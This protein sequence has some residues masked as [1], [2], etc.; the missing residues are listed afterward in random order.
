MHPLVN[1]A[2][3]AARDASKM[4]LQ[5]FDRL[6][7]ITVNE[8]SRNDFV[9]DVD[10]AAE[11]MIIEHIL[12]RYPDHHITAEES[13]EHGAEHHFNWIIDPLDGTANFI[14]GIPHFAISI[15]VQEKGRTI[16]AM[17]YDP[18][19]DELF[20]AA[21]GEGARLNDRKL[22]VS[23][24]KTLEGG[25]IGTGFPFRDHDMLSDYLRGFET[26]FRQCA[27]IRRNGAAAL[28]LAYVAAGRYAGF[29]ELSLQ[30]WDMAAGALLVRESAG[31]VTDA[32]GTDN[33]LKTGS[34]VAGNVH[35]VKS[36][37]EAIR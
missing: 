37:L 27:G 24:E 10:K 19:K 9:S 2:W 32:K 8:K 17:V 18:I 3:Q 1:V 16:A 35:I 31:L 13:G 25:L 21:R 34:I 30:P 36:I 22:R 26:L 14:N 33:Y 12:K 4:M 11:K 6:D 15:A 5:A 20:T 29:W 7:S 28:D 23:K